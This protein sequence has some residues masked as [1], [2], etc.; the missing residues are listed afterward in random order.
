VVGATQQILLHQILLHQILLERNRIPISKI[1]YL[2]STPEFGT[3]F[4]SPP[5]FSG[6]VELEELSILP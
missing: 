2:D 6:E 5:V 4:F 3:D 1:A